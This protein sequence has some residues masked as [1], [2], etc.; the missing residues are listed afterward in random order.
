MGNGT[1]ACG[2]NCLVCGLFRQGRCSPCGG[3]HEPEAQAK[4]VAQ[5]SLLGATCPI[6]QCAQARRV[7]Y[8]SADCRDYPCER[9]AAGPYPLSQGY[10]AMQRRRRKAPDKPA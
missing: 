3:G 5:L 8:C 2:I 10:L 1:G 4:L 6:L 7:P 9:F